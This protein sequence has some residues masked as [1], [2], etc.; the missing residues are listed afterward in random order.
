ME[1]KVELD[2]AAR[3]QGFDAFGVV[4]P[5][6]IPLAPPRLREFLASGAHGDMAWM[7]ANAERRG[8]PRAL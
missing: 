3:A 6:A 1:L 5:D 8:D 7:A 2:E 4:R